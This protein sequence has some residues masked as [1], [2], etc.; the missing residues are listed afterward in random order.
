[1]QN[2]YA[3]AWRLQQEFWTALLPLIP[4]VDDGTSIVVDPAGLHDTRQIGANYWNLPRVLGHLFKFPGSWEAVPR[5]YRL[6]DG[7]QNR[8][9]T[10]DGNVRLD[11]ATTVAPPSS[12]RVV[13]PAKVIFIGHQQGELTRFAGAF[14]PNDGPVELPATTAIGEPPYAHGFLYPLLIVRGEGSPHGD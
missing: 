10:D 13:D 3:T 1:V 4:D 5:V 14:P 7:W 9:L 11:A 2:D 8:I 6:V 12:Y